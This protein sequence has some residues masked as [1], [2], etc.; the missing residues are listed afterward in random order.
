M[1]WS[2]SR[3][4]LLS[5]N[6]NQ[7]TRPE[8][9]AMFPDLSWKA[10]ERKAERL[11]LKRDRYPRRLL[12]DV[13]PSWMIGEMLGDGH[14]APG[15][16]YSHT[17][18]YREYANFLIAKINDMGLF[19]SDFE[20]TRLVERTGNYYYR[21]MVKTRSYFKQARREWYHQG[22]KEVPNSLLKLDDTMFAHWFI[23]DGCVTAN[24]MSRLFLCSESFSEQSL[25]RLLHLLH[26]FGIV[27]YVQ[28]RSRHIY[29]GRNHANMAWFDAF[30]TRGL[31]YPSCYSYKFQRLARWSRE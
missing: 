23:G 25:Q 9:H 15:G 13:L 20:E 7:A 17:T 5:A 8:L 2:S 19:C 26:D 16:Q 30:L 27:A 29:I 24:K 28:E 22:R 18:K 10:I 11:F 4:A 6:W 1:I 14:I 12:V 21:A 3:I 31:I